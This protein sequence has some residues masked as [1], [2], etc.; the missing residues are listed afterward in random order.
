[1]YIEDSEEIRYCILFFKYST[2]LVNSSK[3]MIFKHFRWVVPIHLFLKPK[4]IRVQMAKMLGV[5]V[6]LQ[7]LA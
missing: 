2:N 1:M 6:R 5:V 7:K 4:S 3:K